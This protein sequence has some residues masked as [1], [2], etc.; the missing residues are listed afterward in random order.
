MA[1][2]DDAKRKEYQNKYYLEHVKGNPEK[3]AQR[4]DAQKEYEKRTKYKSGIQYRKK[5][6]TQMSF[7]VRKDIA[8]KYKEKCQQEG[9]TYSKLFHDAIRS[10]LGL[11]E[12]NF[13]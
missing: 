10:F 3:L 13:E 7:S 6:Y 5:T 11:D 4:R 9:I 1:H 12:N 8:E 2:K